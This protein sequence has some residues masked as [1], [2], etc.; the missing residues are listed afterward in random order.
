M[1]ISVGDYKNNRP[2]IY[3]KRIDEKTKHYWAESWKDVEFPVNMCKPVIME[4]TTEAMALKIFDRFGVFPSTRK[5][6]DPVIIG[7]IVH[8]AGPFN[9]KIVSFMI[10]WHLNTNVL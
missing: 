3:E 2:N 7:Q 5:K 8:K 4:A 6:I 10:A 1:P 9:E